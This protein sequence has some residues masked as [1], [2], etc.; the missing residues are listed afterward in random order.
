[1][2]RKIAV[3]LGGD[4]HRSVLRKSHG[5]PLL[6]VACVH[7]ETAPVLGNK[8]LKRANCCRIDNSCNGKRVSGRV[9]F[10]ELQTTMTRTPTA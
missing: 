4:Y 8:L 5:T 7:L 10:S 2:K 3:F 6:L 1:M 9:F